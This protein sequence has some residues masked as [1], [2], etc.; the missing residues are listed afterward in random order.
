MAVRRTDPHC[1]QRILGRETAGAPVRGTRGIGPAVEIDLPAG[2]L[3]LPDGQTVRF[4]IEAFARYCLVN[5]IDEL[6]YLLGQSDAIAAFERRA[7]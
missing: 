2:Q 7:G 5:G 3:R 4:P 1:G 6:G